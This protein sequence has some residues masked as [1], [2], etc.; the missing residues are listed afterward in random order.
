MLTLTS[1][2]QIDINYRGQRIALKGCIKDA[3]N[4]HDFLLRK[5]L[6]V[7]FIEGVY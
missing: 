2:H 6:S 1:F 3:K 7:S 4:I 5:R